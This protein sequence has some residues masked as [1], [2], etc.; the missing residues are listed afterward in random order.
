MK[1]LQ[2]LV[3]A[4][5]DVHSSSRIPHTLNL[6]CLSQLV[7][8]SL[9]IVL[10][11]VETILL[12]TDGHSTQHKLLNLASTKQVLIDQVH[13]DSFMNASTVLNANAIDFLHCRRIVD[14]V[15][16]IVSETLHQTTQ[17]HASQQIISLLLL[18]SGDHWQADIEHF[19]YVS[20]EPRLE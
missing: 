8:V 2:V 20:I 11:I 15:T 9:G 17:Y 19:L 7:V 4:I 3:D 1:L 18:L 10:Q 5:E 16:H 6:H 14:E 13:L 12:G